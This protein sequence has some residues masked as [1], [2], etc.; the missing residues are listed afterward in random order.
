MNVLASQLQLAGLHEKLKNLPDKLEGTYELVLERIK[1]QGDEH[2]KLALDTLAWVL[3]TQWQ[4]TV[5]ELQH[6]L[7][8][9]PGS[10][11][12]DPERIYLE[13]DIRD[14]CNGLVT[15]L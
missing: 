10:R 8:C 3:F 4:L 14:A 15:I 12:F 13:D 1:E 7:A 5:L 9:V 6:A 2:K 11:D